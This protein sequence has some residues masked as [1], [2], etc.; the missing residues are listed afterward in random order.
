MT[1]NVT[2]DGGNSSIKVL[3]EGTK[4]I[5]VPTVMADPSSVDYNIGSM[6]DDAK[7]NKKNP[8]INKLDVSIITHHD[9][10]GAADRFLLG[11]MAEPFKARNRANTDKAKDTDLTKCMLSAVAYAL[12]SYKLENGEEIG[13]RMTVRVNL[14]TGLPY[15]EWKNENARNEYD[16][17][18]TGNHLIKFNHPYFKDLEIE[19]VVERTLVLIEGEAILNLIIADEDN[20]FTKMDKN[21]LVDSI[22]VCVDLGAYTSEIVAKQFYAIYDEDDEFSEAEDFEIG[23]RTMPNLTKGIPYGVGHAMERAIVDI[24]RHENVDNLIRRD[25][26]RAFGIQGRKNGKAGHLV[27]TGI[28]IGNYFKPHAQAFAKEIGREIY[29]LYNTENVKNRIKKI[30]IAGGG[31]RIGTV[32][33]ELKNVLI[34]DGYDSTT[35]VTVT[36]PDPVYANCYGYYV[37]LSEMIRML[38]ELGENGGI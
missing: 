10:G 18:L 32:V 17:K 22:A 11:K 30:F 28:Y 4:K 1:Y 24:Q 35:I 37:K 6:D 33:D 8:G 34:N 9:K 14:A 5:S 23:I 7:R 15:H 25:I 12:Y 26:E 27:G 29:G 13:N 16:K 36:N 2:V 38:E 21:E 31:S 19:L 3:V 20:I